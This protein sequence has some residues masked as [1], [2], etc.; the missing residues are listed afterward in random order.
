MRSI[1]RRSRWDAGA[2]LSSQRYSSCLRVAIYVDFQKIWVELSENL[3]YDW[4]FGHFILFPG[5]NQNAHWAFGHLGSLP[6]IF[7]F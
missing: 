6:D 2:G 1:Q 4:A 5:Q 3:Y 7:G